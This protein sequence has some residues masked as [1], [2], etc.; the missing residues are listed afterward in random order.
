MEKVHKKTALRAAADLILAAHDLGEGLLWERYEQQLPLCAFTSNG[1]NCRKCF[2]G[3]CRISPFGDEPSR[4]VCGADRDQIVMETL[5]QSTREGVLETAQSLRLLGVEGADQGFADMASDFPA[6]T[7]K[8]LGSLRLLPVKKDDFFEV[9]NSYFAHKGYLDQTL[10]DLTRLGLIHYGFLKQAEVLVGRTA[11]KALPFDPEGVNLL[12]VGQAPIGF[13]EAVGQQAPQKSGGRKINFLVQ[14][15]NRLPFT[16]VA[17]DHGSPELALG[18]KVDALVMAP[19]APFPGLET[20]ARKYNLPVILMDRTRSLSETASEAIGR[21]V[22]HAKQTVHGTASKVLPAG[23]GGNPIVGRAKEVSQALASGQLRGVLVL[24]GEANV[25]QTFFDRTLALMRAALAERVLVLLGGDI[26]S[27]MDLL[28][29]ELG[30]ENASQLSPFSA[31]LVKEG[32]APFSTFGS[33]FEIPRVVSFLGSLA[34]GRELFSLPV[35]AAFPEFYRASTWATAVTFLSL[36]CTVQ[37]GTRLPFWGSPSLTEVLLTGWSKITGGKL[38]VAPALPDSNGQA[39]EMV[40]FL[41]T[42]RV[43]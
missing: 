20:L 12:V 29:A 6:E 31:E 8:R 23:E 13:V 18:T 37:V 21:A 2:Q 19:N 41:K 40:S 1:L 33:A 39:E 34:G 32:L 38:L 10:L 28:V 30:K 43:S 16:T 9:Q 24:F 14:G 5:F 7:Q 42:K 11:R 17:R 22:E 27:E 36:G 25:K 26:T 4:G 35:I 15:G 3:P